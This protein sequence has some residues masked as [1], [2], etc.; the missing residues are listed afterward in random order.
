[1][2]HKAMFALSL[3]C[4]LG[5][6]AATTTVK[7]SDSVYTDLDFDKCKTVMAD[8]MGA[9]LTCP[10]FGDYPVHFKEGDLRQSLLYGK[11]APQLIEEA[12]ESFSAFNRVHTKL[13]WR[14][15][16]RGRPF[17]AIHRWYIENPG[18]D[19]SI[20]DKS[21]GQVLVVSRVGQSERDASCFVALVDARAN[22][23]ANELAR[24]AAD[25]WARDYECG[26]E[27]G[28]QWLG[29]RGNLTSERTFYW[30][31]GFIQQ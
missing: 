4:V 8:D 24:Q 29:K 10:G 14:L 3:S 27:P 17:A 7:A 25:R 28:P 13:E 21:T 31:E 26:M 11:V 23:N 16:S 9:Q 2:T 22:S 30:P 6:V 5:L 18:P 15:D 19:G 12:F 1:M 20:S